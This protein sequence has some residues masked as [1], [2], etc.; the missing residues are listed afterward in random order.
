MPPRS[1]PDVGG[2]PSTAGHLAHGIGPLGELTVSILDAPMTIRTN[3]AA[4]AAYL[5]ALWS[6]CLATTP[7]GPPVR[8]VNLPG[9]AA[10]PSPEILLRL[11][12]EVTLAG[13]EHAAGTALMFHAAGVALSLIP[14]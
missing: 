12:S 1:I 9:T 8:H 7:S 6:R 13:I 11:T 4:A 10:I 2:S 14:L 5:R 3:D